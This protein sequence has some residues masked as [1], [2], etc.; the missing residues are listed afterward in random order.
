MSVVYR[1]YRLSSCICCYRPLERRRIRAYGSYLFREMV[2]SR[3]IR[4]VG[5]RMKGVGGVGE[6]PL[7]RFKMRSR[8]SIPPTTSI[9]R[10]RAFL[11]HKVKGT[12]SAI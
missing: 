11:N 9:G 2:G 6:R 7:N 12:S 4:S 1:D 8:R 5:L 10:I 3:L